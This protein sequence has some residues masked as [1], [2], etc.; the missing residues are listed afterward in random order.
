MK[1]KGES[2]TETLKNSTKR[3][4][5]KNRRRQKSSKEIN[6]CLNINT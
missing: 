2:F 5:E 3:K 1:V 4:K 6:N